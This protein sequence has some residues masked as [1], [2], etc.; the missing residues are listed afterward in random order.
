MKFPLRVIKVSKVT[1][2]N[3]PLNFRVIQPIC[4][5]G[6]VTYF[7]EIDGNQ[8][9]LND[10]YWYATGIVLSTVF[11]MSIFHPICLYLFK[12][13]WKIRTACSGIIYQK[14]LRL[15]K[16]MAEDGQ[17]GKIINLL[18]NDL[19]KFDN[20]IAY[21]HE[22]WKGPLEA[23][24]FLIVM[25][26]EIGI[27]AVVGMAFLLSFIPLQ[28]KK[29]I[30]AYDKFRVLIHYFPRNVAWIGKKSAELR[31]K[32]IERTDFRVNIM[33]EILLGIQ[34]IKMYAWEKSFA[35]LVNQI[36]R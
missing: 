14:A 25:Y 3:F 23:F 29:K 16:S 18:S 11:L 1:I 6:F 30:I 8:V 4:V 15:T 34:V 9:T 2:F 5:G 35:K 36:R 7:A 32:N 13:S 10:A 27:A 26:T 19:A 20:M 17:N 24:V 31:L 28:G 33:N 21:F 22:I 12:T